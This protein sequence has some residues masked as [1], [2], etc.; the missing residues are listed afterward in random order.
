MG[1]RR[2]DFAGSWYPGTESECRAMIE[3]F[4]DVSVPC[5]S[6]KRGVSGGIVP[7][8]G[9]YYS[10]QI[11]F[12]VIK[13][14]KHGISPDIFVIFG[15]HLHPGSSNYIMKEGYWST[16]MGELEIDS[17]MAER[18]I[19]EF[20]FTVETSSR[21]EQ[22]NTIELQLPF[23]K[24]LFPDVKILP[25]GAPPKSSSIRIGERVQEI[26]E[27][28]GKKIFIIGSTDLTHYGYNY[29]YIPKGTGKK[30]VE[31]VRNEN[32]KRMIDRILA[33]DTEGIISESLK[34][35]N[36]CCSGA[37]AAAVAALKKMGAVKGEKLIYRTSYDVMPNDSF[38]GYAGI[39]FG[40]E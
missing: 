33:M 25:V 8:A 31:W 34:S 4:S 3:S 40:K 36:A 22:D 10:G 12:N 37:V 27:E 17:Y 7:H 5:P 23:I 19:S 26:A 16:P 30:A 39:V 21:Y 13:C 14:L 20:S 28:T 18:L 9:W 32:D 35:S 24:Y 29:G 6:F 15:R 2:A 38:V 11:A 1:V